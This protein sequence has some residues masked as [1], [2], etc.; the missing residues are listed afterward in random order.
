M[1]DLEAENVFD[2]GFTIADAH[3]WHVAVTNSE[4]G[5][6]CFQFENVQ[7]AER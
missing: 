2:A 6:A 3:G 1:G 7:A 5:D 4:Q